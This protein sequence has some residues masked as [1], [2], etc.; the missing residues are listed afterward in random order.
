MDLTTAKAEL[1][2]RREDRRI[3]RKHRDEA[4]ARFAAE[5][6]NANFE[7]AVSAQ[8]WAD[9]RHDAYLAAR[10]KVWAVMEGQEV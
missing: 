1:A 3:A 9:N 7:A 5:P 4:E 8:Q 2:M 6:T 10:E